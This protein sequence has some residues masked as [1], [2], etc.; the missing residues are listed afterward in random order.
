[1]TSNFSRFRVAL[2]LVWEML[3]GIASTWPAGAETVSQDFDDAIASNSR[4]TESTMR[5]CY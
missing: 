3:L 2:V 5:N 1:M 4:G